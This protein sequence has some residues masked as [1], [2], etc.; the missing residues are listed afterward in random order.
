[1]PVEIL[2][3][4]SDLDERNIHIESTFYQNE[5]EISAALL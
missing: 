3:S 2:Q 4:H 1:M 5:F